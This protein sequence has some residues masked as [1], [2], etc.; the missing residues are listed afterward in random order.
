MPLQGSGFPACKASSQVRARLLPDA[1]PGGAILLGLRNS[2][3]PAKRHMQV[4]NPRSPVKAQS[5]VRMSVPAF[6][7]LP[8]SIYVFPRYS[9]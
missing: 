1:T 2:F 3:E 7:F 5:N 8:L 6:R 4:N 9:G